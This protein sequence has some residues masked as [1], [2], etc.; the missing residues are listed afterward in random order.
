MMDA[1]AVT[2][3]GRA[4]R[5]D[6]PADSGN[7]VSRYFCGTRSAPNWDVMDAAL[8]AFETMPPDNPLEQG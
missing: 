3:E 4:A 6:K 2:I 5:F 1:D 7:M 8:P